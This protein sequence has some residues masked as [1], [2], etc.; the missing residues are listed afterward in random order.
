[1]NFDS[2]QDG[3]MFAEFIA[4]EKRGS[5]M[6]F[7]SLFWAFGSILSGSLAWAIIPK[8]SCC[9]GIC[10]NTDICDGPDNRGWRYLLALLGL[11]N[12]LMF[13]LRFGF[14]GSITQ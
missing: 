12:I 13:L 5:L 9:D 4:K 2:L 10:L 3:A 1:M 7:L 14:P 8:F 6:V 11:T